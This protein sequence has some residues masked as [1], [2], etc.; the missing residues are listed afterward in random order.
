MLIYANGDSF[1]SG[2][3][4]CDHIIPG[5][6]G[7]FTAEE[8]NNTRKKETIEFDR[9]K[10]EYTNMYVE[11]NK[12]LIGDEDITFF[13]NTDVGL[14]RLYGNHDLLEH[15]YTYLAELEKLDKSIKTINGAI[16][17]ASIAGIC[18]RTIL[19]L[20]EL[21]SKNIKVD[22]VIIQLTS[23][24]RYELF[25][26]NHKHFL[27]D[28]PIGHFNDYS[29]EE[30]SKAVAL[31]YDNANLL[32]KYMYHLSTLKETVQSITGKL[33]IIIDSTN[34]NHIVEHLL[35]TRQRVAKD[36]A[37]DLNYFNNLV[38]HSMI[39]QA[40]FNFME[41]ASLLTSKPYSYDGHFSKEVHKVTAKKLL[42]LL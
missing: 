32:I 26:L 12:L 1:T 29:S 13:K 33:P 11:N 15:R 40:H 2:V 31:S 42:E 18:H 27:Y 35:H 41:K 22:R 20:L 5:Y 16:A 8:K 7:E 34:G 10:N 24:G 9:V 6:P 38:E 25:K 17:G 21:K 14:V 39:N 36:P 28:R 3:S 4:L 30:L 23:T 19:D 37:N